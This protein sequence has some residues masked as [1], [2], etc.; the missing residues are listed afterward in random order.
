MLRI[1]TLRHTDAVSGFGCL[2]M[3]STASNRVNMDTCRGIEYSG[4]R[5]ATVG[6]HIDSGEFHSVHGEGFTGAMRA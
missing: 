4:V 1:S 2:P 5:S 6:L 3:F